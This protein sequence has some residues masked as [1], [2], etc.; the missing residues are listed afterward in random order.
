MKEIKGLYTIADN[1]LNPLPTISDLVEKFLKGGSRIIQLR[2]KGVDIDKVRKNA[3]EI[4]K[5][6]KYFDFI[7]IINDFVDIAL[8]VGADGVHV[9]ID[10][11]PISQIRNA[12]GDDFLIGYSSH[13]YKEAVYAEK[14]GASYVALGAIYPTTTK[15]YGHPVVGIETLKLV[16]KSVMIPV[17]A[18]GGINRENYKQAFEAKASAVAMISALTKADDIQSETKWFVDNIKKFF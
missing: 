11:A 10:D 16:T 18:I 15:G 8:E 4:I 1:H 17:V 12:A 14:M 7:F 6:R 2:M 3:F 9:G 13:S 5:Y